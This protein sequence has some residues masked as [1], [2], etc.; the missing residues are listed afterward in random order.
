MSDQSLTQN[1]PTNTIEYSGILLGLLANAI[2][3]IKSTQYNG[4]SSD[5]LKWMFLLAIVSLI[6]S[7]ILNF[8]VTQF[9][10]QT[11]TPKHDLEKILDISHYFFLGG[12]IMTASIIISIITTPNYAIL[13]AFFLIAAIGIIKYITK[14]KPETEGQFKS[15]K[16]ESLHSGSSKRPPRH[17]KKQKTKVF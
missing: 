17:P 10:A 13:S 11:K 6:L 14:T 5:S 1:K 2:I 15:C 3:S 7:I 16:N 9:K 4:T 12:L 8:A